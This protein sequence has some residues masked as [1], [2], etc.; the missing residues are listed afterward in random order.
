MI[1]QTSENTD[2]CQKNN[3]CQVFGNVNRNLLSN[4]ISSK[5]KKTSKKT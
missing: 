1:K 3:N 2:I 4:D 5:K